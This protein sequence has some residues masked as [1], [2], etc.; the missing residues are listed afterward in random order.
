MSEQAFQLL[1]TQSQRENVK[2]RKL[3]ERFVAD[4]TS[5]SS[6]SPPGCGQLA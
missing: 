2:L 5:R 6:G 1:V 3:A 4:V